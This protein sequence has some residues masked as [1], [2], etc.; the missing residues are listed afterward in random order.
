ML[1]M[2]L[3]LL[4]VFLYTLGAL[5]GKP[6]GHA[7]HKHVHEPRISVEPPEAPPVEHEEPVTTPPIENKGGNGA[8]SMEG[9]NGANSIEDKRGDG[10]TLSK[11][12]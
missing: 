9:G 2:R 11:D 7:V 6:A 8:D 10:A 12:S 5:G 4:V 1:Q 3:F